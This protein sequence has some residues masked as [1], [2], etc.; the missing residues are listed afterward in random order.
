MARARTK[1]RFAQETGGSV[2]IEFVIMMPVFLAALAFAFEFGQFFLTYQN[3]ASNVRS[4]ARFLARLDDPTSTANRRLART[5]VRTGQTDS[6]VTPGAHMANAC[7]S[8]SSCFTVTN[9]AVRVD[10]K[11]NYPLTLFG[12]VGGQA[13][14]SLPIRVVETSRRMGS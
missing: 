3:A 6:T 10:V 2:T 5:I 13:G 12:F 11:I 4:A 7:P 9:T 14:A 8:L 1:G